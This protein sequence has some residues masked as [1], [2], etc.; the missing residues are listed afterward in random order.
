MKL[1]FV[2]LC[3]GLLFSCNSNKEKEP[4]WE[5]KYEFVV[6]IA[7][8]SNVSFQDNSPSTI[9]F[10]PSDSKRTKRIKD[11]INNKSQA[12]LKQL[13]QEKYPDLKDK[14]FKIDFVPLNGEV[15]DGFKFELY[16]LE[17]ENCENLLMDYVTRC[18]EEFHYLNHSSNG[19]IRN[20]I[21][22]KLDSLKQ[23][24]QAFLK[25]PEEERDLEEMTKLEKIYTL[26]LEKKT[27]WEIAAA[28]QS[29]KIFFYLDRRPNKVK[30]K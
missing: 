24:I 27:E 23:K 28:G 16:A 7:G 30:V 29:N 2:L 10:E 19:Q 9:G 13:I 14:Q 12:R 11:F 8:T 6:F 26:L 1:F 15:K 22:F 5:V 20:E 25:L 4:N 3:G 17:D 21:N 18:E